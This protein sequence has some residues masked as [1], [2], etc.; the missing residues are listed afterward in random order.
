MLRYGSTWIRTTEE[1]PFL[2]EQ[3]FDKNASSLRFKGELNWIEA[4]DLK[5]N[6]FLVAPKLR[7]EHSVNMNLASAFLIGLYA[8]DGTMACVG[9]SN[10]KALVYKDGYRCKGM[11]IALNADYVEKYKKLF[12]EY[13]IPWGIYRVSD[14]S[15][16]ASVTIT[17]YSLKQDCLNIVNFTKSSEAQEKM[18]SALVLSWNEAAQWELLK[19]FFLADGTLVKGTGSKDNRYCYITLFNTNKAIMNMLLVILKQWYQ[20]KIDHFCGC[21]WSNLNTIDDVNVFML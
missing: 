7:C 12:E 3:C 16:S 9:T 18:M 6:D 15:K 17:D 21:C 5:V 13:S 14:C 11:S 1:H 4:K 8:G 10:E 19:G 2:S 20:C